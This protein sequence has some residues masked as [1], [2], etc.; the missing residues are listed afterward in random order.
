MPM[1]P[2]D[3]FTYPSHIVRDGHNYTRSVFKTKH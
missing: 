1:N 3:L 2:L